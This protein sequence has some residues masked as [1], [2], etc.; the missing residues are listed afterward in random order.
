MN[1][2]MFSKSKEMLT[3]ISDKKK[4]E[5]YVQAVKDI[6]RDPKSVFKRNGQSKAL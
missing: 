5:M 6:I 3:V 4:Y 1:G 2:Q